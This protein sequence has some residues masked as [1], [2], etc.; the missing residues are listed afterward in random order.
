M[1][2]TTED[3]V[4]LALAADLRE[5]WNAE[6]SDWDQIVGAKDNP[7]SESAVDLWDDMPVVDS[8]VIAR[9]SPIFERHLG[10]PLDVKLIR[11]GGYGTIEE[12]IAD[13]VPKMTD[14]AKSSEPSSG[15]AK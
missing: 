14:L 6:A 4:A 10:I 13:L 8:K 12:V 11:R 15:E 5:W 3:P 2:T 1:A 9:T 7:S